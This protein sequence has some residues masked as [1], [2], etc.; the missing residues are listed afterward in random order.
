MGRAQ[1]M[2]WLGTQHCALRV[3]PP[4]PVQGGLSPGLCT[5]GGVVLGEGGPEPG[6]LR[7]TCAPPLPQPRVGTAPFL[8][9]PMHDHPAQPRQ[10]LGGQGCPEREERALNRLQ[11]LGS[12][13]TRALTCLPEAGACGFQ[14]GPFWG[15]G[16]TRTGERRAGMRDG[17][18]PAAQG[19]PRACPAASSQPNCFTGPVHGPC[20]ALLCPAFLAH[21]GSGATV[22]WSGHSFPICCQPGTRVG[23]WPS[24]LGRGHFWKFL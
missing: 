19:G 3:Q 13:F 21:H 8:A 11:H 23:G 5:P 16:V 4:S 22:P 17:G 12:S 1:G 15:S 18:V 6:G 2:A 14:T 7:V 10:G 24:T 9:T 20:T